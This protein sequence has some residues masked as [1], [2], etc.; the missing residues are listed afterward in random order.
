MA[1]KLRDELASARDEARA[2]RE[3]SRKLAERN[4][5]LEEQLASGEKLILRQKEELARLRETGQQLGEQSAQ[6]ASRGEPAI[7]FTGSVPAPAVPASSGTPA[8]PAGATPPQSRQEKTTAAAGT[9]AFGAS[10]LQEE[11][12]LYGGAA[13]AFTLLGLLGLRRLRKTA[14][15]DVATDTLCV[16]KA[17]REE[18]GDIAAPETAAV[19]APEEAGPERDAA[20]AAGIDEVGVA[21]LENAILTGP[22][23]YPRFV[24]DASTG[25]D[26][27]TARDVAGKS[28]LPEEEFRDRIDLAGVFVE[29]GDLDGAREVLDQVL[30][31]GNDD[32]RN[33]AE[34]ILE[35]YA[36]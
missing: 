6:G 9:P 2:A 22:A 16:A 26:S 12:L 21:R 4:R 24:A 29:A 34:E 3:E 20:A 5:V 11:M 31:E 18:R 19:S 28:R 8:D 7:P 13:T 36:S 27:G 17:P 10:L 25:A 23:E 30:R 1:A 14:Q 32:Q 33:A 35:K 15:E